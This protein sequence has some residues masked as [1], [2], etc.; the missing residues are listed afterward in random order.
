MKPIKKYPMK[1]IMLLASV[2]AFMV[3]CDPRPG[4][5][6]GEVSEEGANAGE[7]ITPIPSRSASGRIA[8]THPTRGQEVGQTISIKGRAKVFENRVSFRLRK[9]VNQILAQGGAIAQAPDAGQFGPFEGSLSWQ[10]QEPGTRVILE[11]F[12]VRA[13]DGAPDH[14][15]TIPLV[16]K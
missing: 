7:A 1:Y 15:V 14:V 9:G 6:S 13:K 16:L 10:G 8:V 3:A 11:V 2:L 4:S 12:S 5:P